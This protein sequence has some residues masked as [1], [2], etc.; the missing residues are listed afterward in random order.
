MET[1][2]LTAMVQPFHHAVP[3]GLQLCDAAKK[4]QGKTN[5]HLKTQTTGQPL[6]FTLAVASMLPAVC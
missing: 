3:Q 1:Q 5:H 6:T 2:A 4:K